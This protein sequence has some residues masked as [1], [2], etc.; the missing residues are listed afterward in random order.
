MCCTP[1][2]SQTYPNEL[3]GM[4]T[5]ALLELF[6]LVL[7]ACLQIEKLDANSPIANLRWGCSLWRREEWSLFTENLCQV[8]LCCGCG[9]DAKVFNQEV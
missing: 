6:S 2:D 7:S 9:G 4:G 8:G 1:D 3:T 5:E